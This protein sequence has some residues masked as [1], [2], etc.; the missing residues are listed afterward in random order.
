D[1][2]IPY[3]VVDRAPRQRQPL[4]QLVDCQLAVLTQLA[5]LLPEICRMGHTNTCSPSRGTKLSL[6]SRASTAPH[7]TAP[8]PALLRRPAARVGHRAWPRSNR[9]GRCTTTPRWSAGWMT[10]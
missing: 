2:E 8:T 7:A 10:W 4:R 6:G 5:R 3:P 9:C 1:R